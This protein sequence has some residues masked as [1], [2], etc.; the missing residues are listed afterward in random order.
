MPLQTGSGIGPYGGFA[1][2]ATGSMMSDMGS[3]LF[4]GDADGVNIDKSWIGG[5][6]SARIKGVRKR[7]MQPRYSIDQIILLSVE[8]RRP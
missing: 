8:C 5:K 2:G 1:C 7:P 4:T 3:V 6:V